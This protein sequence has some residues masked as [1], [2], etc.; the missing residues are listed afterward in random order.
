MRSTS[1]IAVLVAL[2]AL[3]AT[4]VEA[5]EVHT[6]VKTRRMQH[7]HAL[8]REAMKVP[9]GG[10]VMQLEDSEEEEKNV[11][12]FEDGLPDDGLSIFFAIGF[13]IQALVAVVLLNLAL[14]Y[15]P[16]LHFSLRGACV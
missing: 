5:K 7:L 15:V 12:R 3:A 8:H 13:A 1:A 16:R 11:T 4:F 9:H 6:A 10:G 2:V 14:R